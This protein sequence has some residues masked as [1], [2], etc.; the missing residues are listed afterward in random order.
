MNLRKLALPRPDRSRLEITALPQSTAH[1]S[2]PG[3]RALILGMLA[4]FALVVFVYARYFAGGPAGVGLTRAH[5]RRDLVLGT[6]VGIPMLGLAA[7]FKRW[8]IP[9]Y[10][11]HTPADHAVQ[12]FFFMA[13][14]APAE[15]LFW[16]GMLQTLTIQQ[17]ERLAGPGARASAAGW[18]L[19]TLG[20]G[21]FHTIGG[22]W[23]WRAVIGATAGGGVFGLVYLLQPRPRS[24]LPSILVHGLAGTGFF[25]GGDA[26]LQWY[27]QRS[28]R[29]RET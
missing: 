24:I 2:I 7:A 17:V 1:E 21:A 5:L 16:R 25:N 10:R 18:A 15:E 19:T 23:P 28:R 3:L 22:N 13:V 6:T 9:Q 11:P 29:H 26:I 8:A 20:F 4:P 12:T 14:N 27:A